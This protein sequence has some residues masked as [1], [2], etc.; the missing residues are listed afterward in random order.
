MLCIFRRLRIILVKDLGPMK[1]IAGRL[2]AILTLGAYFLLNTHLALALP[3]W[4][5][6]TPATSSES[7]DHPARSGQCSRCSK[8]STST[9]TNNSSH[10]EHQDHQSPSHHDCPCDGGHCPVPGGCSGCNLAKIVGLT[11]L[12]FV[13]PSNGPVEILHH[14]QDA[15]RIPPVL[16]SLVRP[17]RS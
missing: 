3:Q 2:V 8:K 7:D 13:E 4:S 14:L 16:D 5:F 10:D 6:A 12:N 17:P 15:V 11:S 1:R 9:S